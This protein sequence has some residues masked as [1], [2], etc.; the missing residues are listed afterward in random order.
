MD[1]WSGNYNDIV[2][3]IEAIKTEYEG[4]L[5]SFSLGKMA[6]KTSKIADFK[7][8]VYKLKFDECRRN[9]IWEYLNGDVD[10][11]VLIKYLK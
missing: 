7:R 1:L 5:A 11:E 2:C 10:M 8:Q 4:I 6:E 9:A 3:K